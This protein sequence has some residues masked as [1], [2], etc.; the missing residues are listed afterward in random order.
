MCVHTNR[1]TDRQTYKTY[2]TH[3]IDLILLQVTVDDI[4]TCFVQY[5]TQLMDH[6]T[7]T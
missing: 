6:V 5:R 7:H 1:Q 3:Y 4:Q 2:H